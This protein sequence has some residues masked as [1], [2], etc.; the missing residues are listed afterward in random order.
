MSQ[1]QLPVP[2]LCPVGLLTQSHGVAAQ[3]REGTNALCS[4]R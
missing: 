1:P 3:T 4:N 2:L